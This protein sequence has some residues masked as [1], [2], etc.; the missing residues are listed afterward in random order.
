MINSSYDQT[1]SV[2]FLR[3]PLAKLLYERSWSNVPKVPQWNASFITLSEFASCVK[4]TWSLS[5]T[6]IMYLFSSCSYQATKCKQT[7]THII[8]CEV[9]RQRLTLLIFHWRINNLFA[10]ANN[11]KL[12]TQNPHLILVLSLPMDQSFSPTTLR[13]EVELNTCINP[14]C[15]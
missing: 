12:Q 15:L 14:S 8:Q 7:L 6:E 2:W 11:G 3:V 1:N 10:H 4:Y 9:S 5:E 13:P